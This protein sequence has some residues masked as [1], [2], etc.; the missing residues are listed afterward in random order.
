VPALDYA[1]RALSA[2]G[3]HPEACPSWERIRTELYQ[4]QLDAGVKSGIDP[5]QGPEAA[6]A[7]RRAA[8]GALRQIH[9]G[10]GSRGATGAPTPGSTD[11]S[12][13]NHR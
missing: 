9:I 4:E 10:G 2:C 7:F 12:P 6:Q 13:G 3:A 11:R 5:R 1:N 8:E